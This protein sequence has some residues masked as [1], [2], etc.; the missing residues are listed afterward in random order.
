MHPPPDPLSALLRRADPAAGAVG[1]SPS[2]FA[3]AVHRR[4]QLSDTAPLRA[5]GARRLRL[6]YPLAAALA[7]M[8]SLGLGAGL[9]LS[10]ERE[11][12][13]ATYAAA[14]VRSIDPWTMHGG[15]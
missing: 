14:Y 4:I 3:A 7:L 12:R 1:P 13:A 15:H 11:S 10:R 6:L 2:G 5:P 8:A 9:A